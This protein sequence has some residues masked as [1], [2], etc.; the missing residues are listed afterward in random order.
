VIKILIDLKGLER[1]IGNDTEAEI[2]IR[3][4][5]IQTFAKKHLKSL[6]KSDTF[7]PILEGIQKSIV[8]M[9]REEMPIVRKKVD[10][11]SNKYKW[12]LVRDGYFYEELRASIKKTATDLLNEILNGELADAQ[13][14]FRLECKSRFDHHT[15]SIRQRITEEVDK[16]FGQ[17]FNAEV[18]AEINR[19]IHE[20]ASQR[21]QRS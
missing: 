14:A 10:G 4:G 21:P 11:W 9:F 20:L 13:Q 5:I 17:S 16:Q 15:N 6:A 7:E 8:A 12:V 1:L 3:E 19:R 2:E 18:E